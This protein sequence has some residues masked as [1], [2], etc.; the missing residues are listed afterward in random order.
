MLSFSYLHH[1]HIDPEAS[2]FLCRKQ[3]CTTAYVHETYSLQQGHFTFHHD[4]VLSVLVDAQT[5]FLSSDKGINAQG[6]NPS[7]FGKAELSKYTKKPHSGLL[8]LTA[9]CY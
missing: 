1:W 2:C 3:V 6:N 9:N 5:P 7:K 8:H 4:S